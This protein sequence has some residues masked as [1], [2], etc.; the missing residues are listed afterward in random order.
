MRTIRRMMPHALRG[1]LLPI[2]IVTAVVLAA[3]AGW[4][5][6]RQSSRLEPTPDGRLGLYVAPFGD[7]ASRVLQEEAASLMRRAFRSAAIRKVTDIRLL[8]RPLAWRDEGA[9]MAARLNATALVGQEARGDSRQIFLLL[10]MPNDAPNLPRPDL[11]RLPS[12]MLYPEQATLPFE[13]PQSWTLAAA[14]IESHLYLAAPYGSLIPAHLQ[15]ALGPARPGIDWADLNYAAGSIALASLVAA[16][17]GPQALEQAV[18][19]LETAMEAWQEE[20]NQLRVMEAKVNLASALLMRNRRPA[21]GQADVDRAAELIES[22]KDAV[23]AHPNTRLRDLALFLRA[24]A[25]LAR[26]P[27]DVNPQKTVNQVAG[28]LEQI[29]KGWSR[30]K[31]PYSWAAAEA[32]KARAW[33]R[34]GD[35]GDAGAIEK[36]VAAAEAA[37]EIWTRNPYPGEWANLKSLLGS[38]YARRAKGDRQQN[39]RAAVESYENALQ[40]WRRES[41]P[42]EWSRD[43]VGLATAR[44]ALQG[45]KPDEFARQSIAELEEAL[46]VISRE[47]SPGE[48]GRV[49]NVL[50]AAW[51]ALA[52][53]RERLEKSLEH[54]RAALE[55]RKP[56]T[57]PLEAS[58][59][60][61]NM[62][63]VYRELSP[64]S[65]EPERYL[66]L[67]LQAY[68]AAARALEHSLDSRFLVEIQK[69]RLKTEQVIKQKGLTPA[70]QP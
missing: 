12:A 62:G 31:E 27:A 28:M 35:A 64:L 46:Q 37:L 54:F 47:S 29:Q 25:L 39:V 49:H 24:Q 45:G 33:S 60:L 65:E 66:R 26:V 15:S 58:R 18:A 7:G 8:D 55:V 16:T 6:H 14:L 61:T 57:N 11:K 34:M 41:T 63:N 4:L 51:H 43:K 32:L 67:S 42:N 10:R 68:D 44:L 59:T 48:W 23:A 19:Y 13:S 17:S 38:L 56:E 50:G 3:V 53:N 36:A 1:K 52:P 5:W 30:E 9:V 2:I 69:N 20:G 70:S 22:L 21:D 40:V